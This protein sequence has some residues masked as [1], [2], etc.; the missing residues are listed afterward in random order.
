MCVLG[1]NYFHLHLV[2]DS[3]G[4]TLIAVSRAATTQYQGVASI[5]HVYP[6]VRS[7]QQ[8]ERVLNEI[9]AAPGL[10]LYTLVE[11]KL[12]ARLEAFCKEAGAPC[13]S[14]LAPVH[15]LLQGYLGAV[16]TPKAGAQ[17][18][19]NAEYFRRIDALNYTMLHD[20]GQL[21]ED[22]EEADVVLVGISRTSKTP[23]SIYL[24]NRGIKTLNIPLVPG[25]TEPPEL[26]SLVKPLV[27]GLVASAERIVQIRQNRLLS[28]NASN[29]S[30]YVDKHSVA[31]ELAN[32]RRL[33][34]RH[35]WPVIDVSRRSIEE[36]AA[37]IVELFQARRATLV[38]Q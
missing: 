12:V 28:L 32:A 16:S 9:E 30:D 15:A 17:H 11:P 24:A 18:M 10:V 1:R 36:T 14:V 8:L 13:L 20:D 22:I 6:L 7:E 27:V 37:T 34:S 21:I 38:A 33:F 4:E 29:E 19:L 5:E 23:T 2:S 25:I 26:H 3:T 31:E 35:D